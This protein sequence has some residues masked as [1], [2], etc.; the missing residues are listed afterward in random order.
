MANSLRR[1]SEFGAWSHSF[2]FAVG[3][4][5]PI[6]GVTS[7]DLKVSRAPFGCK[8]SFLKPFDKALGVSMWP[9]EMSGVSESAG[10]M[11]LLCTYSS[12][13]CYS[14]RYLVSSARYYMVPSGL[15]YTPLNIDLTSYCLA[16]A[17]FSP[18]FSASGDHD[19]HGND[20]RYE[21]LIQGIE[22]HL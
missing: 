10:A 8:G 11:I 15:S 22:N 9:S 12:L 3:Y 20:I 7:N 1:S 4:S 19:L 6:T 14:H 16:M 13:R 5:L 18:Y 21:R 2:K 17:N